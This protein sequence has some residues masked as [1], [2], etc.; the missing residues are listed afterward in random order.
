MQP[1][2]LRPAHLPTDSVQ[3][4]RGIHR[5]TRGRLLWPLGLGLLGLG[6]LALVG[7]GSADP[8][9]APA[10]DAS[11]PQ[12]DARDARRDTVHP[13][14]TL[15]PK[16][17]FTK[18][19]VVNVRNGASPD[20][21]RVGYLR[22]GSVFT[23]TSGEPLGFEGC[24]GGWYELTVGGFVCNGR[25]VIAF[26]GRRLPAIRARQPRFD[27]PLPYEYGL[28]RRRVPMYRR[29]PTDEEAAEFEGYHIPGQAPPDAGPG[30]AETAGDGGSAGNSA[31][32]RTAAGD[33]A[34]SA[35]GDGL[36]TP[37]ADDDSTEPTD[38]GVETLEG[39][40]ADSDSVVMRWVARGFFVSLDRDFRRGARRYWRTQSNGFVPYNAVVV[41]EGSDFHGVDLAPPREPTAVAPA[42]GDAGPDAARDAAVATDDA[43]RLPV[44]WVLSS[45]T[46]FYAETAN[47]R[48]HRGR[49][50]PG[51][52]YAFRVASRV[53]QGGH[54]YFRD[55]EGHLYRDS[56]VVLAERS[57]PPSE[58]AAGQKW[59][60]VDLSRQ[61][62]VAYEGTVP[63]FTTLI[64][65][66]RIEREDDPSRD[67]RTPTGVFTIS[68]KH[69]T[70]TMDG[71]NAIDGPYSI[72]DVPY[73][74]Y[75]QLAY[76][77]HS[78]FWHNAFGR[79]KSHGCIN[80]SPP[81]ARQIFG[82]ASPPKPQGWH[83]VYPAADQQATVVRI[84]GETPH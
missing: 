72:D 27:R 56:D 51:Y 43:W 23:A 40:S 60:D 32:A 74:M 75:F 58:V 48:V 14:P 55:P 31:V 50:A 6:L 73:V 53:E 62:L 34:P 77:L 11:P 18:R 5:P 82:W 8:A 13:D 46:G 44:G 69:L 10:R 70:H 25:D 47:G 2:A 81:D 15:P 68:S 12:R 41:R 24:R 63:V 1:L 45:R 54:T 76:A 22:A 37:S 19:F 67:H 49:G 26:E 80:M 39:L 35:S 59:I 64:S 21:T 28:I 20:A 29:M 38:A 42:P 79:P 30:G 7:C 83:G 17:I 66:G 57:D 33:P 65:S 3:D 71:D 4:S 36:A 9:P 52:H 84:R 78:A 16:R 61:V